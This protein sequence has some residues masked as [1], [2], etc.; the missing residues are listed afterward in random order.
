MVRHNPKSH[1]R[2]TR[3]LAIA[4][5]TV[6]AV[7]GLAA[8]FFAA[9]SDGAGPGGVGLYVFAA[10]GVLILLVAL[11]FWFAYRQ[12]IIDREFAMAEED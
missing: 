2:R 4:V 11:V 8:P 6:W 5:V 1:W 12:R 7:V 3:L 10:E 9:I